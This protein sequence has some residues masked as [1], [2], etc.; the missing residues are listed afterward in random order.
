MYVRVYNVRVYIHIHVLIKAAEGINGLVLTSEKMRS[1]S[2][3][4][5]SDDMCSHTPAV[6]GL[7]FRV[8]GSGFR[9]C[10]FLVLATSP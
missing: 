4:T 5:S 1:T 6:C 8:R 3:A 7:G 2:M 9:V 10:D